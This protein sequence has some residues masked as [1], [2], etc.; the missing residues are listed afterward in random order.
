MAKS[1]HFTIIH[2]SFLIDVQKILN[3]PIT[4]FYNSDDVSVIP[5]ELRLTKISLSCFYKKH[6]LLY[7]TMSTDV[8]KVLKTNS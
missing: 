3:I 4:E 2:A 6:T 1:K 7:E 5:G 8:N